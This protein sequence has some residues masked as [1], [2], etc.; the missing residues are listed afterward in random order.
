MNRHRLEIH[1]LTA[2]AIPK[3]CC[4]KCPQSFKNRTNLKRHV[5]SVHEK[6]TRHI[7]QICEEGFVTACKYLILLA[8]IDALLLNIYLF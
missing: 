6:L 3:F 8:K 5:E 1:G 4:A 2:P 7:C